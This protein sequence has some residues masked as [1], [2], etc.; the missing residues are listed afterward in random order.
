LAYFWIYESINKKGKSALT[1]SKDQTMLNKVRYLMPLISASV[2]ES[3]GLILFVPFDLIRTRMQAN[4]LEYNYRLGLIMCKKNIYFSDVY[5]GEKY[6]FR[7]EGGS[8]I[9][10]IYHKVRDIKLYKLV[11]EGVVAFQAMKF[12]K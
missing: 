12:L 1:F 10:S 2:A 3:F 5:G 7:K 4:S 9:D 11:N 8:N 6:C